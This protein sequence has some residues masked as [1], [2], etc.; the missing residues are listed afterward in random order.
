MHFTTFY[1]ISALIVTTTTFM[2]GGMRVFSNNASD[3][4]AV[5]KAIE[6]N[7]ITF[8][9]IAPIHTYNITNEIDAA[10]EYNFSNLA[11]FLTGGTSISKQQ[12]KK[13]NAI[14]KSTQ[15]FNGY[16]QSEIGILV[17]FDKE[18][19][20]S[21]LETKEGSAGKIAANSSLKVCVYFLKI[22]KCLN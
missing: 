22:E 14:F 4:K 19:P 3:G 11:H 10:D 6:K 17:A 5:L 7:K 1:W 16:G 15:I 21:V 2:Q 18:S 13:L 20:K 12:I 9:L 8:L